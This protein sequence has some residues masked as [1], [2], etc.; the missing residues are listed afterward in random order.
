[1]TLSF[2]LA[3]ELQCSFSQVCREESCSVLEKLLLSDLPERFRKAKAFIKAQ[4]LSADTVAELVSS[5]VVQ[6]LLASTQELQPGE[7]WAP[8][9]VLCLIIESNYN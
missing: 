7:I 5:A 4:G 3:Q 6:G 9:V 8:A 2:C 1:M